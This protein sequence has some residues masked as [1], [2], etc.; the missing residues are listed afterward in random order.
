MEIDA[1]SE[2]RRSHLCQCVIISPSVR[3]ACIAAA[4]S[5]DEPFCAGCVDRHPLSPYT[6]GVRPLDIRT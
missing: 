1:P 6:V 2:S 5:P 3:S 4:S